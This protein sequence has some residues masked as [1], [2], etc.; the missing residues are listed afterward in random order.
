LGDPSKAKKELGWE[1]S[2]SFESMVKE[3]VRNDLEEAKR[4]DLC[5]QAGFAVCDFHE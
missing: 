3:M 2:I 1:P 4:D 5:K